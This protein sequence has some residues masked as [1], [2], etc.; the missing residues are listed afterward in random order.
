MFECQKHEKV[1]FK[2][3]YYKKKRKEKKNMIFALTPSTIISKRIIQ[4]SCSK[5]FIL[6]SVSLKA[7]NQGY[8]ITNYIR[9]KGLYKQQ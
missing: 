1:S 4:S 7:S 6:P 5:L 3:K 2:K 9:T 8:T